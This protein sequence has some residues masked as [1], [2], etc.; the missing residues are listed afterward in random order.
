MSHNQ[1][2]L[3][4]KS[5][6]KSS[7]AITQKCS[8]GKSAITAERKAEMSNTFKILDSAGTGFISGEQLLAA[9]KIFGFDLTSAANDRAEGE[10]IGRNEY[11]SFMLSYAQ[12]QDIWCYAESRELFKSFDRES[13]GFISDSQVRRILERFGENLTDTE[14]EFELGQYFIRQN[15]HIEFDSFL[16]LLSEEP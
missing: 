13:C 14:V 3:P 4:Q 11:M 10:K 7:I 15:H 6:R 9:I 12:T 8:R 2:Q 16:M 1:S 5:T